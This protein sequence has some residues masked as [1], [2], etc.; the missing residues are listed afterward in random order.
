M[1]FLKTEGLVA[2]LGEGFRSSGTGK[3]IRM[4]KQR[5]RPQVRYSVRLNDQAAEDLA[6]IVVCSRV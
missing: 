5:A 4:E 3:G 1:H 2:A 6:D